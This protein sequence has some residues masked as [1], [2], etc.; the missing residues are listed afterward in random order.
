MKSRVWGPWRLDRQ[1]TQSALIAARTGRSNSNLH[2][3][4]HPQPGQ[5]N[6]P[7]TQPQSHRKGGSAP[8]GTLWGV[9]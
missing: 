4:H 7:I 5:S 3:L 6:K 2:H 9:A 8:L 1:D